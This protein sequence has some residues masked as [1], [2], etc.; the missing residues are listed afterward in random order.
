MPYP[1]Y[2]LDCV[3]II[4]Y[5]SGV[6]GCNQHFLYSCLFLDIYINCIFCFLKEDIPS[7]PKH[8]KS[9]IHQWCPI[10]K[11]SL[12][13]EPK[14]LDNWVAFNSCM[15]SGEASLTHEKVTVLWGLLWWIR[16]NAPSSKKC[17]KYTSTTIMTVRLLSST[18]P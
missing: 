10:D 6:L 2:I 1:Y 13:S 18:L 17:M 4:N 3:K 11:Y 7:I 8:F 14:S 12:S 16:V 5:P 15:Q 9:K